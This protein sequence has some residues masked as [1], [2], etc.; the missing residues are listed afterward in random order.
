MIYDNML[1]EIS[2]IMENQ[3]I[4]NENKNIFCNTNQLLFHKDTV[5]KVL[6][7]RENLC[8]IS[9]EQITHLAYKYQNNFLSQFYMI[10]QYTYFNEESLQN[11]RNIFISLINELQ[12]VSIPIED[13]ESRHYNRINTFIKLSNPS[14]F[15]INQ[16]DNEISKQF[17]CAQY[18][19]EFLCDLLDIDVSNIKGL[20]LDIGCGLDGNLVTYLRKMNI[21]ANGIDRKTNAPGCTSIDWFMFDYDFEKWDLIISNL[22]FSSHFLYHHLHNE[23]IS[24]QYASTYMKIL[25]SL[26][27]NGQWVYAPSIPFFEDVLPKQLYKIERNSIDSEFLK[28]TITKI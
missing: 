8:D 18:T 26:K 3:F 21:E 14:I 17:V 9:L 7:F 6:K 23:E 24:N 12:E 16:N 11:I 25:S 1:E 2:Q 5:N 4:F 10:N 15:E 13:I 20:V 22:S 19:G 27:K 28:T